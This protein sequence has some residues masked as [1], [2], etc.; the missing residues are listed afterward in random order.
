MTMRRGR[1]VRGVAFAS[2]LV[3][4]GVASGCGSSTPTTPTAAKVTSP[5]TETWAGVLGPAGTASHTFITS[6]PGT[7]T[8][9][10]TSS[11]APLGLGIGIPRAVNGGCRLATSQVDAAGLVVSAPADAGSYC[12]EVF[13]DGSVGKQAGFAVQIVYP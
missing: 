5:V 7:I 4:A 8:V 10:M 13:D 12:V 6:Q 1:F 9:T 3:A 2:L 11:D